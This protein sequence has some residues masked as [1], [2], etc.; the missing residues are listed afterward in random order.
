MTP[1]TALPTLSLD[2]H[3][4]WE[5]ILPASVLPGNV[6]NI[7]VSDEGIYLETETGLYDLITFDD[8]LDIA[9]PGRIVSVNGNGHWP[10]PQLYYLVDNSPDARPLN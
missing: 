7:T 3:G 9:V 10:S 1:N 4:G 5:L 2:S 8:L 6:A